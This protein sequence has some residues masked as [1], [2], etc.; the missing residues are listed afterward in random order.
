MG[1]GMGTGGTGG[2]GVIDAADGREFFR[3]VRSRLSY[4]AF[5]AFLAQIKRLNMGTQ[6]RRT[7]LAEVRAIL[8][9]GETALFEQFEGLIRRH[10]HA[11]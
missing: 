8:G 5:S 1:T 7:T 3:R 6:D 9:E 11:K 10:R 2:G 4:D